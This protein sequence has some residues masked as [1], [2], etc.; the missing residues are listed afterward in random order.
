MK[1]FTKVLLLCLC[2][3]YGVAQAADPAPLALMKKISSSVLTSLQQN[4]SRINNRVFVRKM[5]TRIVVP[6]FDMGVVARS[7]IGRTYWNQASA[8]TRAAFTPPFTRYV[9]DMYSSA[10]AS[11]SDEK[12]VFRPIRGYSQTQKRVRVYST[13]QRPGAPQITLNYRLFKRGSSWKIYDFSV[14]GISMV[15]SY[16][17]QFAGTLKQGGL[18]KLTRQ[19][20]SRK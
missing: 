17:A 1:N 6:H 16:R 2:F 12:I 8:K 20:Q 13:I 7:V 10:I 11:Y 5:I 18:A 15:Q 4:K 9:I 14:D 3:V 19:L